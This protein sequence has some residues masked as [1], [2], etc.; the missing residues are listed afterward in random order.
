MKI[1]FRRGSWITLIVAFFGFIFVSNPAKADS[2]FTDGAKDFYFEFSEPQ[3]FTVRTYAIQYGIDSQ[4]WL[5][6]SQNNLLAANDDYYGLDSYILYNIQ[7]GTYRLRTSV[8]CGNPDLWYGSGYYIETST[9]PTETTTT[10]VPETTTT[11]PETTTTVP[12]TTTTVIETTTTTTLPVTTTTEQPSTTTTIPVTTTT[13]VLP[14]TTTTVIPTT[15][16][17]A[18]TSTTTTTVLPTTTTTILE[19]TTTTTIETTTTTIIETTTTTTQPSVIDQISQIEDPDE[20]GSVISDINPETV[21]P[22]E[23][24]T[25]LENPVFEELSQDEIKKVFD[26]IEVVDLTNEQKKKLIK[27]VNNA[28]DNVKKEFEKEVDVFASGLDEYVPSGSNVDVKT[29]RAIIAVTAVTT[30]ISIAG[31]TSGGIGGGSS[32]GPS[33]GSSGG[34]DSGSGRRRKIK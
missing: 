6:D 15:T 31:A 24:I 10:T 16:V 1:Q 23:I 21:T 13:T 32:S 33:G 17:P 20:L 34:S 26:S 25:I 22:D 18:T 2:Y 5:Y 27:A 29:R 19:T 11:V 30:T 4:L 12:E 3:I 7:P 8:C 14:S 9:A 28:S